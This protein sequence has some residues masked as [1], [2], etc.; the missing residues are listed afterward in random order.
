MQ[1]EQI[2]DVKP[3]PKFMDLPDIED[4]SQQYI[5]DSCQ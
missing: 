2:Q 5:C 3:Q 4:P 1:E